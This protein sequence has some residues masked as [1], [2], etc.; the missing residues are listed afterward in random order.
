MSLDDSGTT[1]QSFSPMM[2]CASIAECADFLHQDTKRVGD[3]EP[4]TSCSPNNNDCNDLASPAYTTSGGYCSE[5]TSK[6]LA[7]NTSVE[8]SS[9]DIQNV[10]ETDEQDFLA[11]GQY[12]IFCMHV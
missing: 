11:P 9:S 2:S 6:E 10:Q 8:S 5:E 3:S 1:T 7:E 12:L 4:G